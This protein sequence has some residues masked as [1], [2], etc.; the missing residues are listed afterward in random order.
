MAGSKVTSK[1]AASNASNTLK[2]K[3]TGSASK[4][5]AGSALSQTQA[6]K[7]TTS[8]PAAS[9]ASKVLRDGRTSKTSQSAAGSALSEKAPANG[10]TV[11]SSA[12]TGTVS[13]AAAR[14]AAKV[15]SRKRS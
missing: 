12:K 11:K 8:T 3:S 5:A 14:S 13:R 6:P 9:A 2:N 10:R 1:K 7:K 4:K 15:V